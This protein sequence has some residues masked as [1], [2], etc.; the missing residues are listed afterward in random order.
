MIILNDVTQFLF[1]CDTPSLSS[2]FLSA[3]FKIVVKYSSYLPLLKAVT[4]FM[5]K[6]QRYWLS[7]KSSFA[8]VSYLTQV[9]TNI[10]LEICILLNMGF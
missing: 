4:S 3:S 1:I 5:N 9:S 2:R 8:S 7:D 10:L 6:P